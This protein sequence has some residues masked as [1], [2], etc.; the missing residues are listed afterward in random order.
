MT[1]RRRRLA[2]AAIATV[3]SAIGV[4]SAGAAGVTWI[5]GLHAPGTPAKFN[6]VGVVKIGSRDARNVLVLVPGTSAGG[7]YFVPLAK[8]LVKQASGGCA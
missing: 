7:A 3:C 8:T 1:S 6:R 2:L 5:P 4:P